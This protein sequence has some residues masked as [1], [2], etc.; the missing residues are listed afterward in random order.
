MK[1]S[2]S[3]AAIGAALAAF[4]GQITN[5][6]TD[7]K[8]PFFKSRYASLPGITDHVR[9]AA[10]K[11]GLA[12]IQSPTNPGDGSVGVTTMILHKSGEWIE[13][14]TVAFKPTKADP[15]GCMAALTYARRGSL[16]AAL[17]IVG[18]PDDDG[19]STVQRPRAAEEPAT[20]TTP[21]P[22]GL[23]VESMTGLEDRFLG[24][25]TDAA[26]AGV[27]RAVAKV[28]AKANTAQLARLRQFS[29]EAKQRIA[30][31][32]GPTFDDVPGAFGES[33]DG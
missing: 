11:H 26:L 25:D 18:D 24:A 6:P 4:Q 10:A 19:N 31:L 27:N 21:E 15:Q 16:C 9:G 28:K 3:M 1:H 8:N 2:E 12:F 30:N 32:S 17:N 22:E 29:S 20:V 5:P 14:D 7:A 33:T 13:T 23:S